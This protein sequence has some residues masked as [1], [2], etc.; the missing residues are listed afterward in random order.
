[1]D[2]VEVYVTVSD[3]QGQPVTGL[4][5]AD[6]QV[7]EDGRPQPIAA[8]AE[9]DVPLGVAVAVDH[10]FSVSSRQLS[11]VVSGA[12]RF[13]GALKPGDRAMILGVGSQTETLTSLSVE[14]PPAIAALRRLAPWGTTPLYDA[15]VEAI[16]SID[17]VSGRRAL[18]LITDGVDRYSTTPAARMIEQARRRNVLVYPVVLGRAVNEALTT[19]GRVTGGRA[20]R[21]GDPERLAAELEQIAMELRAQYLLGFVPQD[22]RPEVPVWRTI[23]VDV[24]KASVVVRAREG[25]L[26]R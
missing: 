17:A 25:Y 8:F 15:V 3:A 23:R 5:P 11:L 19:L 26:A 24:A 13:L 21:V 12:E 20:I 14:R 18:V 10:S 16:A 6:F 1:M 22:P 7:S 9:A 2:L 4:V